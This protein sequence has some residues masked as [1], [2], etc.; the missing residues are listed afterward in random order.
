MSDASVETFKTVS[1]TRGSRVFTTEQVLAW[2]KEFGP[3]TVHDL[4]DL[5]SVGGLI[6]VQDDGKIQKDGQLW[7]E[8]VAVVS[9]AHKAGLLD[10]EKTTHTNKDT[11]AKSYRTIYTYLE[12]PKA[13]VLSNAAKLRAE[14]EEKNTLIIKLEE[15]IA[16]LEAHN[17]ALKRDLQSAK[18]E[19]QN[20]RN[21]IS[22]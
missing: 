17:I 12:T 15:R 2:I 13:P 14:L 9:A 3:I 22:G 6:P 20:A 18:V 16:L 5:I 7:S 21:G 8:L 19:V 10:G 11:G 4:S 1:K